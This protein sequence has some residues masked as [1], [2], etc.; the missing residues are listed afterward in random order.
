LLGLGLTFMN[1]ELESSVDL[2]KEE[3]AI[4]TS[5]LKE[6]EDVPNTKIAEIPAASLIKMCKLLW[7][8]VVAGEKGGEQGAKSF[9]YAE[10]FSPDGPFLAEVSKQAEL[11]TS[12][13]VARVSGDSFRVCDVAGDGVL[14][15]VEFSQR[16]PSV[17]AVV[18]LVAE[19]LNEELEPELA[20]QAKRDVMWK[21]FDGSGFVERGE[22]EAWS[23]L[24]RDLVQLADEYS[25]QTG[26]SYGG[27]SPAERG[28]A[29]AEEGTEVVAGLLGSLDAGGNG[30]ISKVEAADFLVRQ[31]D[32]C[33]AG[34][35]G[36]GGAIDEADAA[37]AA[38][39]R[40]AGGEYEDTYEAVSLA[41]L[42]VPAEGPYPDPDPYSAGVHAVGQQEHSQWDRSA[43]RE[44]LGQLRRAPNSNSPEVKRRKA[45]IKGLL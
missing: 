19:G 24:M 42:E 36:R 8:P 40:S 5:S 20:D 4:I 2:T 38:E 7:L 13:R 16:M 41:D 1:Y 33:V 23:R 25:E 27:G 26:D 12:R 9:Q 15:F 14:T 35:K 34:I 45:E 29:N 44:E 31:V 6:W 3:V 28:R 43:L 18:G 30:R 22:L 17:M 32:W 37:V 21:L 39:H 10:F 11:E